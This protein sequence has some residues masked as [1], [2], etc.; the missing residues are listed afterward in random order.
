MTS[1]MG[2][3]CLYSTLQAKYWP[4]FS[5]LFF[6][7]YKLKQTHKSG[8]FFIRGSIGLSQT[9]VFADRTIKN[10]QNWCNKS[11]GTDG[12]LPTVLKKLKNAIV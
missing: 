2:Y 8:I 7:K 3:N 9:T 5:N 1:K 4:F 11:S 12:I 10:P 6:I